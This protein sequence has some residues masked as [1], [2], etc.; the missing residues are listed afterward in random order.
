LL[1]ILLAKTKLDT[2]CSLKPRATITSPISI[3]QRKFIERDNK[4]M[5]KRIVKIGRVGGKLNSSKSSLELS[6]INP[7]LRN[8]LQ[9][10]SF[11]N[12]SI[13]LKAIED[14]NSKI[15]S[16]LIRTSPTIRREQWIKRNIQTSKYK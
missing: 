7:H 6:S 12:R 3:Y 4:S 8:N 15:F 9:T 1:G 14:E 11:L 5:N 2:H 13:K 16:R 10:Y